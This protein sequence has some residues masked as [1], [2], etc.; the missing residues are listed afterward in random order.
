MKVRGE[1]QPRH[2]QPRPRGA[3]AGEAG[4]ADQHRPHGHDRPLRHA[5]V[6]AGFR[7]RI[8][9]ILRG[10]SLLLKYLLFYTTR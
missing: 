6:E 9:P 7:R 8:Q 3:Q 4:G 1:Q 5:V 2:G 10:E